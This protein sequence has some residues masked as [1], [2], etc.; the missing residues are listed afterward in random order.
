M[1]GFRSAMGENCRAP[2]EIATAASISTVVYVGDANLTSIEMPSFGSLLGAANAS[3]TILGAQRSTDTFRTVKEQ[4]NYSAGAG[5]GDWEIPDSTGDYVCVCRPATRFNYIKLQLST[6]A[7]GGMVGDNSPY[8]H[9]Q[10]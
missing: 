7:T 8:I 1:W 3:V 10:K 9:L 6:A 2:A 4:G 5:I